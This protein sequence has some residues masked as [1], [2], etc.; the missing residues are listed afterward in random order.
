MK[1]SARLAPL[2]PETTPELKDDF[3]AIAANLGFIP[4]SVLIMQRKPKLVKALRQ[5]LGAIGEPDG[6]VDRGF[7]RLVAHFC[8]RAAGCRYCMA[9]TAGG[10]LRFGVEDKK[11]AAL[12]EYRSS[13]LYSEAERV[14]LDFALAAG[15]VPNDVDE[16]MFAGMRKHWSEGQIVE[17]VGVIATFGFLNRWND[18]MGTPLEEEPILTGEKYLASHG[19]TAGK[20][21][22]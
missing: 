4:N 19:W 18:T 7:K 17:I 6:E 16:E 15:S 20:H 14:A 9:H 10:A 22:R 8:S 11:L 5:M 13:A 1:A 21:A 3:E 2:P 12:W